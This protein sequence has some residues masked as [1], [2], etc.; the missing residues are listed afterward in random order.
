MYATGINPKTGAKVHV[1][2]GD[3]KR[4]QRALLSWRDPA[5]FDLVREGLRQAG[6]D[7]LIGNGPECLI[8]R[9]KGQAEHTPGNKSYNFV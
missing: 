5:G 2:K 7:D 4:I 3:E 8:G 6:R 9:S 1:P